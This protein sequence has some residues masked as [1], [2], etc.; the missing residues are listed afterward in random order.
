[1]AGLSCHPLRLEQAV[2]A[3]TARERI[4]RL[5]DHLEW[6]QSLQDLQAVKAL[7]P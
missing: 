3:Q 7:L 6:S 5:F 4:E 2:L 1:M